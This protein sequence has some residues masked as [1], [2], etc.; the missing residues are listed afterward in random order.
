M[1]LHH[2]LPATFLA[3]FSLD[4]VTF[5]RRNRQLIVGNKD[6]ERV[7]R[8]SAVNV[9]AI[10]NLYTLVESRGNPE[11]IEKTW[12]DFEGNLTEA[13]YLLIAGRL[14]A[15]SWI[16]ILV[17]FVASM[18]VRGPDFNRRFERRLRV[19][20]L[21]SHMDLISEDNT[22]GARLLELQRLLGPVA[23]AKWTVVHVIGQ[24]P[25]ITN[26]LGYAPYQNE[27]TG[28]IGIS[29]PL[30]PTYTL[31]ISP[32]TQ[33]EILRVQS[34]KWIPVIEYFHNM[35]NNHEG[36]NEALSSIAQRFIFGP[37]DTTIE[38]YL[39]SG[40]KANF[41]PEPE[42]LGF[43]TDPLARAHEFTWHRL[44]AAIERDPDSEDPW[45]FDLDWELIAKGWAPPVYFPVNLIE[46][47][48]VLNRIN[49]SIIAEFYNPQVYYSLSLIRELEQIGDFDLLL[50]EAEKGIQFAEEDEHKIR[51]LVAKGSAYDEKEKYDDAL[52]EYEEALS[53]EPQSAIAILNR[54]VTLLKKGEVDRALESFNQALLFD[55]NFALAR[56]N[57]GGVLTLTGYHAAAIDDLT[58]ALKS[59]PSGPARAAA[60][61]SRGKSHI[62]L[63]SNKD[64]LQDLDEAFLEYQ[65][66]LPKSYCLFHKAIALRNLG[67]QSTALNTIDTAIDLNEA[68]PEFHLL[69][70]ELLLQEDELAMAVDSIDQTLSL[71]PSDSNS[72]QAH[73]YLARI[74]TIKGDLQQA[75]TENNKAVGLDPENPSLHHNRGLTFLLLGEIENAIASF[76]EAIE[77]DDNNSGAWNNRGIGR[78]AIGDYVG[79]ISDHDKSVEVGGN[80]HDIGSSLRH[81]AKCHLLIGEIAKAESYLERAK[82][83]DPN[84]PFNLMIEGLVLL[85][86]GMFYDSQTFLSD[87]AIMQE[88]IPDIQIY[89]SLPRI[90]LGEFK[91][92]LNIAKKNWVKLRFSIT[93]YEFTNHIRA[94]QVRFPEQKELDDLLEISNYE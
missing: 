15:R 77:R 64:A 49:D 31:A 57:R 18:L 14:D 88:K 79:A 9:A 22:N 54:G 73:D 26:D 61:L 87:A 42:Q 36:L 91:K 89:L 28:E 40:S 23:V 63:E 53:L 68:A 8:T 92:G 19:I 5:P 17:P 20:G 47:P 86:R 11:L 76:T 90:F 25:L 83:I 10:N 27:V 12:A 6:E 46:F 94:L 37:D 2:Y 60:L 71:D 35:P 29:I 21:E 58:E 4:K 43:I 44:A 84:S 1:P 80:I 69:R 13:I 33:R 34:G 41:P 59:I 70:A 56:V 45:E 50:E 81:L 75:I 82:K 93:K 85:Y 52:H 7:F 65:D 74:L 16:R 51:F 24:E 30:N 39:S 78:A 62:S 67:D 48:P 38:K 66:P 72:A 55:P 3:E 32:R